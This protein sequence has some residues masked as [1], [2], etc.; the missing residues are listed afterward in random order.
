MHLLARLLL[1]A[2]SGERAVE[3]LRTWLGGAPDPEA[4]AGFANLLLDRGEPGLAWK[5]LSP[6]TGRAGDHEELLQAVIATERSLGRDEQAWDRLFRLRAANHLPEG[7]LES[8]LDLAAARQAVGEIAAAL[9]AARIARLPEWLVVSL[10]DTAFNTGRQDLLDR[11]LASRDREW[12]AARPLLGAEL[13]LKRGDPEGARRLADDAGK[14]DLPDKDRLAL[15]SLYQRLSDPAAVLRQME[16]VNPASLAAGDRLYLANLYLAGG[17]PSRGLAR[18]GVRHDAAWALL[19]V[20]EEDSGPALDWIEANDAGNELLTACYWAAAD[21]GR[22]AARWR[23]AAL[24]KRREAPGSA[25]IYSATLLAAAES[26]LEVGSE[27]ESYATA[28]LGETATPEGEREALVHA[29]LRAGRPRAA[30]GEAERLARLRG[31]N[32]FFAYVDAARASG[33]TRRLGAFLEKELERRDLSEPQRDERLYVLLDTTS[34][35]RALPWLRRSAGRGPDWT[36][37][38]ESALEA[39]GNEE[40]LRAAW[41]RRSTDSRM[42]AE[43]RRSAAFALLN[44]SEKASAETAFRRLADETGEFGPDAQQ[45]L[46]L[47]GPRPPEES[48]AWLE[49]RAR[50]AAPAKA[51]VWME[52]LLHAGAAGKAAAAGSVLPSPKPEVYF[53]ALQRAGDRAALAVAI[54]KEASSVDDVTRLRLLAAIALEESLSDTAERTFL[55][56]LRQSPGDVEALGWLARHSYASQRYNSARYYLERWRARHEGDA[57]LHLLY[58]QLLE[59][60]D[61]KQEAAGEYGKGIAAAGGRSDPAGRLAAA[62]LRYRAEGLAASRPLFEALAAERPDDAALAADWIAVLI[63]AGQTAEAEKLLDAQAARWPRPREDPREMEI[64]V[65]WGKPLPVRASASGRELIVRTGQPVPPE[66]A[67]KLAEV[68][69]EWLAGAATGYDSVLLT[70]ALDVEWK[71]RT[72]GNRLVIRLREKHTGG[73]RLAAGRNELLR[74]QI[75]RLRGRLAQ[76]EQRYESLLATGSGPGQTDALLGLAA[77]EHQIGHWRRADQLTSGLITRQEAGSEP[78]RRLNDEVHRSQRDRVEI[79]TQSTSIGSGWTQTTARATGH[80]LLSP[81]LRIGF[82]LEAGRGKVAVFQQSDGRRG[83]FDGTVRRGEVYLQADTA[84]GS[85]WRASLLGAEKA[86]AALHWERGDLWGATSAQA[87]YRRPF[88]GF[89]EGL[90][91]GGIRDRIELMRRQRIGPATA[92]VALSASRY[93]LAALPA[94]AS[95]RGIAG[96]ISVPLPIT[97]G[98]NP[99]R[100]EYGFD[101]EHRWNVAARVDAAGHSFEP[102]PFTNREIHSLGLAAGQPIRRNWYWEAGAGMALDRLGGRGPYITGRIGYDAGGGFSVQGFVDRRLYNLSSGSSI[103]GSIAATQAGVSV[104]WRPGPGRQTPAEAKQ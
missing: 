86:G 76:A 52:A 45:L 95:T 74:A 33:E 81:S 59:M 99:W 89:A 85:I 56:L 5:L 36:S 30:L 14:R 62:Q 84:G 80:T 23:L 43:S 10:A 31:G 60:E 77:L 28:R 82:D 26:G 49:K 8:Y 91:Q 1:D 7:L 19:A 58:G 29:L 24:L 46:Y 79:A 64:A 25:G 51:A 47:W 39:L 66:A 13:A 40:E 6:L 87:E 98:G 73:G 97:R 35:D 16:Q 78:A 72:E 55:R 11:L 101:A 12:T 96:G 34:L 22:L 4:V 44:A 61:R 15:A 53:R 17:Q 48:I 104:T 63:E 75:D 83:V 27:L 102:L 32:W 20:T 50:S 41:R 38:Y 103:A 100:F 57:E 18:L 93:G 92:W 2:G 70:A 68:P 3:E 65:D 37:A 9:D 71:W 94:A 42:T 21:H 69:P 67:A 90:A 88:W 54:D